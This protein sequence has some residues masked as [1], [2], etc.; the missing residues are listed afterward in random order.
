MEANRAI[1]ADAKAARELQDQREEVTWR[2]LDIV[3]REL[4]DLR[5]RAHGRP[6]R[7]RPL[8]PRCAKRWHANAN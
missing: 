1:R 4:A 6:K 7:P 5:E 2:E 3:S 8:A